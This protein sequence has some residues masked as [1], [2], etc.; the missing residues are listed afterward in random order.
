VIRAI[1]RLV[2]TA[3]LASLTAAL[4]VGPVGPPGAPPT[5][6]LS[7]TAMWLQHATP[8]A[9]AIAA[10]RAAA[11]ALAAHLTFA[12]VVLT[13]AGERRWHRAGVHLLVPAA[14]R[15]MVATMLGLS[16]VAGATLAGA[17][18][19]RPE[20]IVTEP[21]VCDVDDP[22]CGTLMLLP[23][24]AAQIQLLVPMP[25]RFVIGEHV[26]TET[27]QID[28]SD[29]WVVKPG[30]HFWSIARSTRDRAA[31]SL[32]DHWLALIELNRDRLPDPCNPDLVHPGTELLLP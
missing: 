2:V 10:V 24:D 7:G 30:E 25:P 18:E 23:P 1:R 31:G 20:P 5:I 11:A 15:R 4:F 3:G 8:D 6:D 21:A 29:T 16:V 13:V 9:I 19:R 14:T 22:N 27:D 28:R 17:A 32:H 26:D 12:S